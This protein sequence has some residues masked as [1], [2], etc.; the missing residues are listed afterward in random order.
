M[1]LGTQIVELLYIIFTGILCALLYWYL[2]N[3]LVR[4]RPFIK[5]H[6]IVA[7]TQPLDE[8]SLPS[9]HTMNAVNFCIL[10]SFFF[11]ETILITLPFT[12]LV[13]LSRVILGVHYP[14]DVF[15]G[16]VLGSSIA[17]TAISIYTW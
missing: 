4:Q 1:S 14:S 5:N 8:Y 15:I 7:Y 13:A 16:A 3:R 9:G 10:L 6:E 12:I 2:K 17:V 11:P